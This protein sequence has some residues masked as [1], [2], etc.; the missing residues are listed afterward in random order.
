MAR[1][2]IE[3]KTGR[4]KAVSPR[5]ARLLVA[6][7]KAKLVEDEPKRAAAARSQTPPAADLAELPYTEIRALAAEHEVEAESRKKDDLVEA[8]QEAGVEP[9]KPKR[10]RTYKRRD[11]KAEGE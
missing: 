7:G 3:T 11:I 5:D 1:V 9:P 10:K 4:R 2:T 8:L 6:L